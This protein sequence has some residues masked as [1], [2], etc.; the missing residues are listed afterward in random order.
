MQNEK[1]V[2]RPAIQ[3]KPLVSRLMNLAKNW[4]KKL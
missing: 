4:P 2:W 3:Q 1:K